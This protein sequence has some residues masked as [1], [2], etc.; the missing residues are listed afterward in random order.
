MDPARSS[1][2]VPDACRPSAAAALVAVALVW[3]ALL[4]PRALGSPPEGPALFALV[5]AL[6]VPLLAARPRARPGSPRCARR[7]RAGRRARATQTAAGRALAVRR[8]SG[9]RS[10][11]RAL[12]GA[13]LAG[14][15]GALLLAAVAALAGPT[16]G[17]APP[18][19][20]APGAWS[21]ACQLGPGALLEELLY[22]ERLVGALRPALGAAGAVAASSALFAAAHPAPW[23]AAAAL[24]VGL[25]LGAA[26]AAT[27]SLARCVAA[28][29]GV[30]AAAWLWTLA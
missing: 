14:F 17:V 21:L 24:A 6:C 1:T 7:P 27:G 19:W 4:A 15:A 5:S 30:N 2:T 9:V 16:L 13:A 23:A 28:H 20:R 11:A 22:R 25:A 8:E 3:A 29:A 10:R 12:L 18:A 26:Y